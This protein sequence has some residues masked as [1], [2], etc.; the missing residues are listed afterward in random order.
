MSNKKT[1]P[2]PYNGR[3]TIPAPL[4]KEINSNTA[5]QEFAEMDDFFNT[6]YLDTE[7]SPISEYYKKDYVQRVP[8]E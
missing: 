5:W 7:F 2:D 3:S 8:H 4:A 6:Q 1:I